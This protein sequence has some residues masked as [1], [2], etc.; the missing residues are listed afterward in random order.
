MQVPTT[1]S[2]SRNRIRSMSLSL[3]SPLSLMSLLNQNLRLW[4]E[5]KLSRP[6]MY[7][8]E[9]AEERRAR[10]RATGSMVSAC[11]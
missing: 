7:Y 10:E 1:S 5:V 2:L 9:E 3:F 4:E 11:S 6:P 8:F